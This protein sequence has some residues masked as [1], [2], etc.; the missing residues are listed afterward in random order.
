[1]EIVWELWY[2][3][4]MWVTSFK[5]YLAYHPIVPQLG[6]MNVNFALPP[7]EILTAGQGPLLASDG[8]LLSKWLEFE[9]KQ[10]ILLVPI[11]FFCLTWR[12]HISRRLP[13]QWLLWLPFSGEL[14]GQL[15]SQLV[16]IL[17][18][19]LLLQTHGSNDSKVR[20]LSTRDIAHSDSVLYAHSIRAW[21]LD[22]NKPEQWGFA[23]QYIRRS[24]LCRA[25]FSSHSQRTK[26]LHSTSRLQIMRQ[27]TPGTWCH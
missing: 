5:I 3:N 8:F 27:F 20:I 14:P 16:S 9:F 11:K 2:F 19:L 12:L 25:S 1:M 23:S 22:S 4:S 15:S 10:L 24:V 7:C 18:P 17:A 6:R 13:E 21:W 26:S